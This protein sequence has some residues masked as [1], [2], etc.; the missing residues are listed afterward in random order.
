MNDDDD[1]VA[2]RMGEKETRSSRQ[3]VGRP[4]PSLR[5][6]NRERVNLGECEGEGSAVTVNFIIIIAQV[7]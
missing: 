6:L 1:V 4:L 3:A 7:L 5:R 2:R